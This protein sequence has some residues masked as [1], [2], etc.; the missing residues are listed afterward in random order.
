MEL[1]QQKLRQCCTTNYP[2]LYFT[3]NYQFLANRLNLRQLERASVAVT[4]SDG[5]QHRVASKF[6]DPQY[7]TCGDNLQKLFDDSHITHVIQVGQ[8]MAKKPD[9][10]TMMAS[11]HYHKAMYIQGISGR[12]PLVVALRLTYL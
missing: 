9:L 4:F 8:F 5:T 7:C 10:K 11:S 3:H 6:C 1:I 12:R 2:K